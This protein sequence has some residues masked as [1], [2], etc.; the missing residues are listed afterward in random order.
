M[1]ELTPFEREIRKAILEA[2]RKAKEA[3]LDAAACYRAATDV[4]CDFHPEDTRATAASRAVAILHEE[5]GTLSEL[6][7]RLSGK[8]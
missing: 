6:A 4:W 8:S 7:K 3:K 2:Y 1:A 5:L